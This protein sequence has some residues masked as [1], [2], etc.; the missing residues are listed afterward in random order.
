MLAY[1]LRLIR[2]CARPITQQAEPPSPESTP[3]S[4]TRTTPEPKPNSDLKN[5]CP[6][7]TMGRVTSYLSSNRIYGTSNDEASTCKPITRPKIYLQVGRTDHEFSS[8]PNER[9]AH[10]PAQEMFGTSADSNSSRHST[11][12][13]P[14]SLGNPAHTDSSSASLSSGS[15]AS[16]TKRKKSVLRKIITSTAVAPLAFGLGVGVSLATLPLQMILD[17]KECEEEGTIDFFLD[18]NMD[19]F[20]G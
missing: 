17:K 1:L 16:S 2:C 14:H 15:T 11:D 18:E 4:S 12:T 5:E 19:V 9:A 20:E 8:T 6:K 3:L 13:D 7:L 10:V